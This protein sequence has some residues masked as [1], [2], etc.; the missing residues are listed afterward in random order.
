MQ[1]QSLAVELVQPAAGPDQAWP[2]PAVERPHPI[3]WDQQGLFALAA[4]FAQAYGGAIGRRSSADDVPAAAT[5]EDSFG[6]CRDD[7]RV[8][9]LPDEAT[10][11]PG[12]LTRLPDVERG[13]IR[14]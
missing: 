6:A 11:M 14:R 8:H 7:V 9:A 10:S 1:P 3:E 5:D 2:P 12:V 13:P 4:D